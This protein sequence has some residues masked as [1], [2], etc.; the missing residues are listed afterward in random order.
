VLVQ[1]AAHF[2]KNATAES[3]E[4]APQF[5]EHDMKIVVIGGSGLVGTQ[6]V[7]TLRH[8]RHDVVAASRKTG[9]NTFTGEGLAAAVAGA[10][11]VVDVTN[12]PAFD[13]ATAV[14]F[15]ETSCRNLIAA[16]EAARVKH[17][18]VLS[19]V[20][21]D[22]L[23][24]S[25]YFRAK[26]IQEDLVRTSLIPHTVLRATQFFEFVERIARSDSDERV[27]PAFVQPMA[28]EE[29]AAALADL[30]TA[31]P[32]NGMIEAA[33]PELFRLDDMVRRVRSIHRDQRQVVTDP[34]APYYGAVLNLD[35][36]TPDEGAILGV[37]RFDEW[38]RRTLH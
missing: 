22:R 15:F 4:H 25:G 6:L 32:R 1:V 35:T 19:V 5:K 28:S 11:V 16:S 13:D 7:N 23:L 24:D 33:G 8:R 38:V 26:M 20:G 18:V 3:F 2:A 31:S 36:L 21:T 12:S 27:S 9:V 34:S 17:H 10:G 29:V 37:T 30:A 14:E